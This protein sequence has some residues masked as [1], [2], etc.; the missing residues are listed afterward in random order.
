MKICVVGH[1]G[2]VGHTVYTFL[3]SKYD[4]VVGVSQSTSSSLLKSID[5]IV[6]CAGFSTK[7][8]A[9]ENFDVALEYEINVFRRIKA[10]QSIN[11]KMKLLHISS[12]AAI[13]NSNYGLIKQA[14]E[15]WMSNYFSEYCILRLAGLVGEGLARN[16][17]FDL[18][19]NNWLFTRLDSVYNFIHTD[20]IAEIV[21][22]L[23]EH[24][25]S[26]ESI[27]IAAK[28]S[29]SVE[30]I[31]KLLER[32]PRVRDDAKKECFQ[33]NTRRL[34]SFFETKSSEYYIAQFFRNVGESENEY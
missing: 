15:Y 31:A 4:N 6:N 21:S 13:E 24:W 28:K 12:I 34:Q 1:T 8:K 18:V 16:V 19:N 5:V 26:R 30:K 20:A 33:V 14:S 22:Y 2:F 10:I 32:T 3:K 9:A 29:I 23:I 25:I 11:P 17:V 7:Y 27:N